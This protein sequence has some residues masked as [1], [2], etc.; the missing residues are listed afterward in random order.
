MFD[1]LIT[2]WLKKRASQFGSEIFKA[3]KTNIK[4]KH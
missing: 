2:F 1:T 4:C 3:D